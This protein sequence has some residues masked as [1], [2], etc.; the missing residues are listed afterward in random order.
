[1]KVIP[2]MKRT[3][4]HVSSQQIYLTANITLL[5]CTEILDCVNIPGCTKGANVSR[6]AELAGVLALVNDRHVMS[7]A[8]GHPRVPALMDVR[9]PV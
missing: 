9:L 6:E 7:K 1:M 5:E 3:Y 4:R 2:D 8:P